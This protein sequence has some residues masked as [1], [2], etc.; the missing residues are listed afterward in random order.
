VPPLRLKWFTAAVVAVAA[1]GG[2][3]RSAPDAPEAVAVAPADAAPALLMPGS[4]ADAGAAPDGGAPPPARAPTLSR[5]VELREPGREP[6]RVLRH[7]FVAGSRYAL[8][9]QISARITADKRSVSAVELRAPFDV[10]IN[11]LGANGGAALSYTLGP[12]TPASPS[13]ADAGV[14]LRSDIAAGT[15]V[16]GSAMVA[17]DGQLT[18]RR[19]DAPTRERSPE[20]ELVKSLL[21]T[22]LELPEQPVG[23]G[24]RWDVVLEGSSDQLRVVHTTSYELVRFEGPAARIRVAENEQLWGGPDGGLLNPAGFPENSG[25]WLLRPAQPFAEGRQKL[26]QEVPAET[27]RGELSTELSIARRK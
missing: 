4:P 9:V 18:D 17:P 24:A 8:K 7:A 2:V 12:I 21:A 22:A 26:R 15:K 5:R 20:A 23:A 14:A 10:Q 16:S 25:E 13:A 6:R 19:L 27:G 1:C 3:K 11:G